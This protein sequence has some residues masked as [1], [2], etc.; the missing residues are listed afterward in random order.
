MVKDLVNRKKWDN[1]VHKVDFFVGLYVTH[2]S[3]VDTHVWRS[4]RAGP[5][6]YNLFAQPIKQIIIRLVMR[7]FTPRK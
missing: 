7:Y 3:I 4:T 6:K 2:A 5:L 1:G